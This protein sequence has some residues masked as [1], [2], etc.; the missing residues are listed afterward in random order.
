MKQF[1]VP[2]AW[3]QAGVKPSETKSA[4]K[5]SARVDMS[6]EVAGQ[7]LCPDCRRPMEDGIANEHEVHVCHDCRI[8]IPKV[9]T[10]DASVDQ[11]LNPAVESEAVL[12]PSTA[13][14]PV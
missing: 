9:D 11:Q 6:A 12:G 5:V 8:A 14:S 13:Q 7:G 2:Q 1:K 10:V 3:L 4:T